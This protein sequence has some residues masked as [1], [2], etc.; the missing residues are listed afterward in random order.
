M[1]DTPPGPNIGIHPAGTTA[2]SDK[3]RRS[4]GKTAAR[5]RV[6]QFAALSMWPY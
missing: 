4:N 3:Q 6:D 5:Q 1:I 2:R